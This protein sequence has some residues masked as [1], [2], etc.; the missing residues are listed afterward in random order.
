M[1]IPRRGCLALLALTMFLGRD[2]PAA[3]PVERTPEPVAADGPAISIA[4]VVVNP[5]GQPIAGASVFLRAK[6]GGQQYTSGLRH[7]RDLLARTRTSAD[8]RFAFE[9]VV[10]PPRM[11]DQIQQLMRTEAGAE[12]IVWADGCG[13]AW[14][15]VTALQSDQLTRVVL[16]PETNVTG[17]VKDSAGQEVA[18]A[19][20]TVFGLSRATANLDPLFHGPGDLGLSLSEL[21]LG[22]TSD[23]QG[24]F[25]IAHLPKGCRVSV[26]CESDG[27]RRQPFMLETGDDP[28]LTE[29]RYDGRETEPKPLLRSPLSLVLEPQRHIAVRVVDH[30]GQPVSGGA[31]QVTKE[32]GMYAWVPVNS[33]G[34]ASIGLTEPGRLNIQYA[35]DPLEPRLGRST[36]VEVTAGEE[37]PQVEI[38]LPEPRW[39]TGRVVDA[40]TGAPVAG[41]Y[42]RYAGERIDEAYSPGG[43]ASLGVSGPDG[44]FRLPVGVG[45]GTITFFFHPVYGYLP[46]TYAHFIRKP[47][48]MPKTAVEVS[49]R[50][51]RPP[52]TLKL[53]RGLAV[54]G[55]VRDENGQPVAGAT[56]RGANP[57]SP[58]RA[59]T[60]S[61]DAD[62]RFTLTGLSPHADAMIFVANE[63]GRE[64]H[65]IAAQPEHPWDQTR[66]IDVEL[67]LARGVT[68]SGRILKNG[69]PRA[70]VTIKLNRSLG[71]DKNRHY[72]WT[73]VK[74]DAEGKYRVTGLVAGDRYSFEI[75]DPDG[76]MA[77]DWPHQSP[78]IQFVPSDKAV[79]ELP[80]AILVSRGQRLRGMVVDPAG[81]PVAGVTVSARLA[82]GDM[83]SRRET[84]PPPWMETEASG[85]FELSQLPD[86]PIELMAY[87]HN[88]QTQ[89]IRFPAKVRPTLNQ[90]D[91]KI[92][93]DP[94]LTEPIE[95]LDSKDK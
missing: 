38:R 91:I 4:G 51:E 66:W 37:S 58:Y 14:S 10:I 77:L 16:S 18:G 81:K 49:D 95:D 55:T 76:S 67:K 31:V 11:E 7:N 70:G 65:A 59:A 72:P 80:D 68:L 53:G 32:R 69:K 83:L 8:G 87:R 61:S 20:F 1:S 92:I 48:A 84:G 62:G 25:T 17:V 6:I 40:D 41:V 93:L 29:I 54:R 19:R 39:Q 23:A 60:T 71:A 24:R 78:Y 52:L 26:L 43:I 57:G 9:K 75:R 35:S 50:G 5:E 28:S 86:E 34:E 12:L 82:S 3:E 47:E 45:K 89:F 46:P 73:E 13:V 79:V 90:D 63:R 85:R 42:L 21:P 15:E 88:G 36:T 94:A 22:A 56:V 33:R 44:E 74:T 2:G 30:A 64:H 27:H